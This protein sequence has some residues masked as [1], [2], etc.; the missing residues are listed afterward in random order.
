[1]IDSRVI[2]FPFAVAALTLSPGPDVG[3]VVRNVLPGVVATAW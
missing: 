2:T 1:M 3:P